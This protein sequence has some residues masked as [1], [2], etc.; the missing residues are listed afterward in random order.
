M[1]TMPVELTK[2]FDESLE[3]GRRIFERLFVVFDFSRHARRALGVALDLRRDHGSAICL[4]HVVELTSGDDW[5]A[6]IGGDR[7]GWASDAH[8][9]LG[10]YVESLPQAV[11]PGIELMASPGPA[12]AAIRA[13]AH[14]WR[15]TLIIA[16]ESVHR[17]LLASPG[18]QLVRN[19]DVPTLIIPIDPAA[20]RIHE[21]R[22]EPH[23]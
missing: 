3:A 4:F 21:A 1:T 9:M 5:V 13:A 12:M 19:T 17:V 16:P 2:A 20:E 6:G 15:A 10:R 11:R 14:D 22:I 7:A 18:E 23:L 8:G